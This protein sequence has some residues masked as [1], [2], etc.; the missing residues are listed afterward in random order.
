MDI[1]IKSI[2]LLNFKGQRSVALEFNGEN[3]S[4][5]GANATGKSTIFD[6]FTWA[7]FGKDSRGATQFEIKTLAPTGEVMWRLPHSVTVE[8]LVD[9]HPT[10]L[11]REYEEKWVKTRGETEETF[12]GHD[13]NRFWNDVPCSAGEFDKK[14]A[15]LC[16]ESLFR[17]ITNPAHFNTLDDKEKMRLLNTLEGNT[18]DEQFMAAREFASFLRVLN[19]KSL[20]EYKRELAAKI[21][22]ANTEIAKLHT[23]L[24]EVNHNLPEDQDWAT[25]EAEVAGC[26]KEIARL[27]GLQ[28]DAAKRSEVSG[29]ER[30]RIQEEINAETLKLTSRENAIREDIGAEYYRQSAARRELLG[31][32]N[33]LR[34]EFVGIKRNS[35]IL[36][37][38][39][40]SLGERLEVL[41]LEYNMILA[42]TFTFNES[43]GVCSTCRQPLP[44][45][46]VEGVRQKLL[47]NFNTNKAAR[48]QAN[49]DDGKNVQGEIKSI[50][51]LLSHHKADAESIS[52][53]LVELESS[54][55][56]LQQLTQP[57]PAPAI[58]ADAELAT[59][60][61]KIDSLREQLAAAPASAQSNDY[62]GEERE[63]ARKKAELERRLYV[64]S[65]IDNARA[66][67]VEIENSI[68]TNAQYLLGLQRDD[69]TIKEIQKAKALYIESRI[70]SSFNLVR[71]KMV[72]DQINGGNRQVCEATVGGVPYASLNN[73]AR[74]N[75]GLDI[76]NAFSRFNGITAPV[77]IDNAEAVNVL[78]PM[79]SQVISLIVTDD[80]ELTIK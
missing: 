58:E 10:T 3:K 75:V 42:E 60:R 80:K 68:R 69:N 24:D 25:I 20:E 16:D 39:R 49:I 19:G 1:R 72:T 65:T 4:L 34:Q 8:L 22:T 46:S 32:F 78:L 74:I 77:F 76:I 7:L 28:S 41:S 73:A 17:L 44:A 15:E 14:V 66:R 50:E 38:R 5:L 79:P 64:R 43:L 45:D 40:Q 53:R 47:E 51:E 71:F 70:N 62:G 13:V 29:K 6:A 61:A 2:K 33:G 54:P 30:L 9:G 27:K 18:T 11:R 59:M 36:I 23:R 21:H 52:R 67:I 12:R 37:S 26:D 35:D 31:E 55:T 48:L 57:D 56:M 63:W